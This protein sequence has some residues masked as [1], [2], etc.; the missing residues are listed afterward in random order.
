[1]LHIIKFDIWMDGYIYIQQ[2]G[3]RRELAV[4]IC[5]CPVADHSAHSYTYSIDI[6]LSAHALDM[7]N[8]YGAGEGD[9]W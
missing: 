2:S 8:L 9:R 6:L 1:V 5:V 3:T 4:L 7:I